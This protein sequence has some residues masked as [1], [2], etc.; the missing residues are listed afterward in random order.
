MKICNTESRRYD[1]HS[2][3][4]AASTLEPI[5]FLMFF[6]DFLVIY[7][8]LL[9]ADDSKMMLEVS[10]ENDTRCLQTD[11]NNL[12]NWCIENMIPLNANK[13]NI[14]TASRATRPIHR[15]YSLADQIIERKDTIRDL[16]VI[17][18]RKLSFSDHIEQTT[19]KSCQLIGCIQ[20]AN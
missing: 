8:V 5:L 4:P 15:V 11:I 16:G 18:N 3:I 6:N 12:M 9:F 13:C 20:W 7:K 19:L 1:M 17:L 2:E 10:N 14:F